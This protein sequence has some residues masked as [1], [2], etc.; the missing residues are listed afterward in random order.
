MCSDDIIIFFF[1][2]HHNTQLAQA[3]NRA[4]K[5]ME[6]A[7]H[8]FE[9]PLHVEVVVCNTEYNKLDAAFLEIRG[10]TIRVKEITPDMVIKALGADQDTE[11]LTMRFHDHF[12]KSITKELYNQAND[13]FRAAHNAALPDHIWEQ[14]AEAEAEN[15]A[16]RAAAATVVFD[17]A[18]A[19]R[20]HH[21]L[22]VVER[23]W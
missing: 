3:I 1:L 22:V 7:Y 20:P 21:T 5:H 16:A 15:A 2:T 14:V 12:P 4:H 6:S 8:K 19:K 11:S 23:T 17:M 9:Q 13:L 10:V 18:V